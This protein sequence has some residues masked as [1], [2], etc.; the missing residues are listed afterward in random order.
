MHFNGLN[1]G[2]NTRGGEGNLHTGLK[3]TG[4]DSSY[5]NGTDTTDLV[6]VLKGES[7]GLVKRSLGGDNGIEG[8]QHDGTLVPTEVGGSLDHVISVPSG[9][10]DEGDGISVVTNLLQVGGKFLLDFLVSFL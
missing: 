1:V 8:F 5:G 6:N 4:F 2:G 10:G 9:N 7:E 3:D